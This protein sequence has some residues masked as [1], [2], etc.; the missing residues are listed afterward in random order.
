VPNAHALRRHATRPRLTVLTA[1]AGVALAAT[2]VLASRDRVH[3]VGS[4]LL[5]LP[6]PVLGLTIGRPLLAAATVQLRWSPHLV[7]T[8]APLN[9]SPKAAPNPTVAF[10]AVTVNQPGDCTL[11]NAFRLLTSPCAGPGAGDANP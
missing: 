1:A 9:R 8:P 6:S 11:S 3:D 10:T 2:C 4:S 7:A 5:A